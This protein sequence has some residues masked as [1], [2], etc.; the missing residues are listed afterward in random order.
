MSTVSLRPARPEDAALL[1]A[2]QQH[3]E[4]RRYACNPEPPT[5]EEHLQW[6][7]GVLAD[8]TR[9]L[10]IAEQDSHAVG[11]LRLDTRSERREVSIVVAPGLHRRGIG[12]AMLAMMKKQW[13]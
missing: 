2:W 5:W 3:P 13:P 1:F 12:S 6:L 4:T 11:M 9:T 7:G 8:D 10:L